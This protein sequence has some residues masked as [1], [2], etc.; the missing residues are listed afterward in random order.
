[1]CKEI[2]LRQHNA[3][4]GTV[5]HACSREPLFSSIQLPTLRRVP[6]KKKQKCQGEGTYTFATLQERYNSKNS[7][8]GGRQGW[9]GKNIEAYVYILL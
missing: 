6:Q 3:V 2:S 8:R 4:C 7:K 9:E 1:M 5:Q